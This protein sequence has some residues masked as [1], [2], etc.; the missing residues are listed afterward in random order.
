MYTCDII[1]W[2]VYI[3]NTTHRHCQRS[4][5]RTPPDL[6]R[7][8]FGV[9]PLLV[10]VQPT[11]WLQHAAIRICSLRQ[12]ILVATL[13]NTYRL[14][15][16]ATH[17]LTVISMAI[18]CGTIAVVYATRI[19]TATHWN[20]HIVTATRLQHA[21]WLHCNMHFDSDG[22]LMWHKTTRCMH[23]TSWLQHT[24]TYCNTRIDCNTLYHTCWL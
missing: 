4:I 10:R 15:R 12:K 18:W 17:V 23:R 11:Y 6:P 19:F 13:S 2:L 21:Y 7:W 22:Y 20:T 9:A 16:T 14:Q 5:F 1:T 3:C 24:A 8:L